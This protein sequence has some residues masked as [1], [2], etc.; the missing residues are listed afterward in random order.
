MDLQGAPVLAEDLVTHDPPLDGDARTGP[1]GHREVPRPA[2]GQPQTSLVIGCA[3][4]SQQGGVR[5]PLLQQAHGPARQVQA[6]GCRAALDI[7]EQDRAVPGPV[8]VVGDQ[9]VDAVGDDAGVD[10]EQQTV[11]DHGVVGG[12]EIS[13]GLNEPAAL[14]DCR[15]GAADLLAEAGGVHRAEPGQQPPYVFRLPAAGTWMLSLGSRGQG[16]PVSGVQLVGEVAA[17]LGE[18][19]PLGLCI[20]RQLVTVGLEV[21]RPSR[22]KLHHAIGEDAA[23]LCECLHHRPGARFSGAG[24]AQPELGELPPPDLGGAAGDPRPAR[25]RTICR[26]TWT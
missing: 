14:P 9:V 6:L 26:R 21:V 13:A 2:E 7:G 4:A 15:L 10:A 8:D 12:E 18:A 24:A 19:L 22:R 11:G 5:Q 16:P 23:D 17:D 1:G 25:T 20:G 3:E